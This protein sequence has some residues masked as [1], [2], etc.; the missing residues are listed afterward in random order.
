MD[1]RVITYKKYQVIGS[2]IIAMG[3]VAAVSGLVKIY[4]LYDRIYF[5]KG[6]ISFGVFLLSAVMV[7]KSGEEWGR[8]RRTASF[9]F[10]LSFLLIFTEILGTGLRLSANA[11][12]VEWS[13][14][15]IFWIVGSSVILSPMMQPFFFKLIN[16]GGNPPET[17]RR[18][19]S[20]KRVFY[21]TWLT[22]FLCYLPCFLA[23]FPGLYCY[24][25]IWQWGMF[26]N[27]AFNTHHP[28]IHTLFAGGILE[29]GKNI[30]GTYQAGL[31]I[32]SLVQ[33]AVL[34]GSI[35]F[36]VR[37]M[38]KIRLSRKMRTAAMAFYILFPFIPITGLSTTKD[39]VFG[40]LFLIFFVCICDM[41][42]MKSIYRGRRLILFLAASIL[43]G[44]FRNNAVYGL[45][46]TGFCCFGAWGMKA[47][48]GQK[49][50]ILL[51][52]AVLFL[53]CMIG[54]F[55][56]FFVMEKALRASKG[57]I[58]EMMSIPCQQLART[59]VLQNDSLSSDD[60]EEMEKF[61]SADAMNGYTYYVSDPVKSG[62]HVDYLK[63]HKRDFLNLWLRL[64]GRYTGEFILAP[65]YNTMGIWY[66]GGDS[67]CYVE[68][69][70][71]PP[72]D[73][74]H[75]VE[76]HSFFPALRRGY[77]WFTDSNIQESLP[78]LSIVFYTSFYSWMVLICT[79]VLAAWRRYPY[80]I[81]SAVL[82]GYMISLIPGPCIIVRYMFGVILCV[83]VMTALTF[84]RPDGGRN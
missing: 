31:A 70:M 69:V 7:K 37:F 48:S 51:Q 44:L 5:N 65:V 38:L 54:T 64:G 75:V 23:F 26:V 12:G 55:G 32:H 62:L 67:S 24:D 27:K 35:A 33:L 9:A 60:K 46:V 79:V 68:F 21:K 13:I 74:E 2:M 47:F 45:G 53:A 3:A 17:A 34:S 49:D 82:W 36:A 66:M 11:D 39:V 71:S 61:I 20:L 4:G 78:M 15:V 77:S 41:V 43:M 40:C 30:F 72:F 81:L 10:L 63:D 73:E 6:V 59:Y 22:L 8:D 1:Y 25:M 80:L 56:S 42:T 16:E 18:R 52:F 57:S 28:L 58:G 76:T 84:Y 83:P 14:P 19:R 29:M 50:K